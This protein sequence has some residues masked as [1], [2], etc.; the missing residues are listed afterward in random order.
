MERHQRWQRQWQNKGLKNQLDKD[1]T[2][3][4]LI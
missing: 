1:P 4:Y 3:I 2:E